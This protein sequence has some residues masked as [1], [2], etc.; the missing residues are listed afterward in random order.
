MKNSSNDIV[1]K[2]AEMENAIQHIQDT[3]GMEIASAG[4][5][6]ATP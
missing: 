1:E 4:S 5:D 3:I 6:L 2:V